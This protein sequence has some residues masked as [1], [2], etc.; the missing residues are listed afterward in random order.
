MATRQPRRRQRGDADVAAN[1]NIFNA[2]QRRAA[3]RQRRHP[4]AQ[5]RRHRRT[6]SASPSTNQGTIHAAGGIC[7]STWT[8]ADGRRDAVVDARC[9]CSSVT[10]RRCRAAR[11]GVTARSRDDVDNSGGTVAAG[12]SPAPLTINGNYTQGSGGT[13]AEEI[14]GHRASAFDRLLVSGAATLDG[15]LAI[16][17][18]S[19]T[20]GATDTFK[21]ISG[22]PS[23]TG[24]FATLTGA[25]VN[26]AHLSAQYDADGVTLLASL[27]PPSNTGAPSI[28]AA[29]HPGD[30]VTCDPGELDRRAGVRVRLDAR[31]HGDRRADRR[32]LH[33]RP[34]TSGTS[35]AAASSGTT[36]AATARPRTQTPSPPP[37]WRS[38]PRPRRRRPPPPRLPRRRLPSRSRSPRSSPCRARTSAP[39]VATS[40]ST[41][42]ITACTRSTQ[43]VRQRQARQGGQGHAPGAAIDL[44]GLPKGTIRVRI[45]IRYREGKALTGVRTYHT[46]TSR[47]SR[48]SGTV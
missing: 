14:T 29:G 30:V 37:S 10:R 6:P 34:T 31:R 4:D 1:T 16:D 23:R 20:P 22:A 44:R 32:H 42:A 47:G 19:F 13:L 39:A 21:I 17:S 7:A 35:C 40:A 36:P 3:C 12:A 28:P 8:H 5:R 25:D 24:S 15:T 18:S 11:L 26:G 48:P 9:R 45:T 38:R 2:G 41:C 46:C 27:T 33:P 43:G